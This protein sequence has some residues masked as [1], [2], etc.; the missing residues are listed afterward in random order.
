MRRYAATGALVVIIAGGACRRSAPEAPAQP[1]APAASEPEITAS[2]EATARVREALEDGHVRELTALADDAL[3][4][5]ADG[6]PVHV[7][8]AIGAYHD[9]LSGFLD[10]ISALVDGLVGGKIDHAR[11]RRAFTQLEASLGRAED[12]FARAAEDRDFSLEACLAC[13]EV[14]W[15]RQGGIDE[16][17]R[18]LFQIEYDGDGRPI[19]PDDPRRKPT[20]RF[21]HGDIHWAR[22]MVAFQ[23][24]VLDVLLA[25]DWHEL[26]RLYDSEMAAEITLRVENEERLVQAR[27]RFLEGLE[28][29]DQARRA[30][31]AETDDDREWMPSPSQKSHPMPLPVDAALYETWERSV[32]DLVALIEGR[33]GLSVTEIAQ[34]GDHQWEDPPTG[35]IDLGRMLEEPGNIVIPVERAFSTDY[36]QRASVEK[37]LADLFGAAYR[38]DMKPSPL[39]SRLHRM[40]REVENGDETFERKLRYLLWIN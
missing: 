11:G 39:V 17:D 29:S 37:L 2:S 34:L 36:S 12:S 31:L 3:A 18:L 21:D 20:F 24:G 33:E 27:A 6:S 16:S 25:Y 35:F 38:P 4:S 7:A 40:K 10:E 9:G 32:A 15:N 8:K 23:R 26:D 22:A 14:D 19:P 1:S 13:W 28:H 5:G 30:Y